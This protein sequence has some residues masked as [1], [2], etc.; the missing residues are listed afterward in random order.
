MRRSRASVRAVS[1]APSYPP[2]ASTVS[3]PA[4]W[5]AVSFA[6]GTPCGRTTQAGTPTS[7]A[8]NATPCPW[9]PADAVTTP[10]ARA[11][12]SSWRIAFRAPRILNAPV[13]CRFSS[14]RKTSR[15]ARPEIARERSVGVCRTCGAM[16]CAAST[17]DRASSARSTSV[18]GASRRSRGSCP[19]PIERAAQAAH[20]LVDAVR[21]GRADGE[22]Q[23][24]RVIARDGEGLARYEGDALLERDVEQR[25]RVHAL[26]QLHPEVEAALGI[27]P[28]HAGAG[29]LARERGAAA[30]LLLA[31][32][33]AQ[34]F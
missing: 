26:R 9:F 25:A 11:R 21:R 30:L 7:R 27:V 20:T 32:E 6:S 2:S 17:T 16:R 34:T 13:C 10:A 14:L 33:V 5:M 31:V 29:E 19:H 4:R 3:A 1:C 18:I 8:A 28:A 23:R 12:G 15:P 24:A 22:P